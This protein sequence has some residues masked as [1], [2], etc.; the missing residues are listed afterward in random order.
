MIEDMA[1]QG[2]EQKIAALLQLMIQDVGTVKKGL[3]S[4]NVKFAQKWLPFLNGLL[5]K[6]MTISDLLREVRDVKDKLYEYQLGQ[7]D[8]KLSTFSEYLADLDNNDFYNSEVFIEI[9]GQYENQNSEPVV[10]KNVKIACMRKTILILASIR[11][12]KRLTI[13][14]SNEK[15]YNLLIKGGEDLRLDQ[16]V[17]QLFYIMNSVFK[18]DPACQSRDLNLKTFNVVPIT[19]R[20]GSLEWVDNTEPLK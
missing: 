18:V 15:D 6:R 14:G 9:P 17:Q 11:R 20:L 3:G 19:N 8:E 10:G 5:K 7:G 1:K 13:H 2:S 4:Y 12:P 16:R